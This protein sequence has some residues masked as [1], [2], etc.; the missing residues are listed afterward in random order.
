MISMDKWE[1]KYYLL[2]ICSLHRACWKNSS[3]TVMAPSSLRLPSR[4]HS[5]N[6]D[7]S[8]GQRPYTIWKRLWLNLWASTRDSWRKDLM[9]CFK[10]GF[11]WK[12]T[13]DKLL[14]QWHYC[15]CNHLRFVCWLLCQERLLGYRFDSGLIVTNLALF[16]YSKICFQG[17]HTHLIFQYTV[18][19][20]A[21]WGPNRNGSWAAFGLWAIIWEPLVYSIMWWYSLVWLLRNEVVDPLWD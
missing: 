13:F 10:N 20:N 2:N 17:P 19:L 5:M 15:Y 11:V 7:C 16:V 21:F 6:T 18:H 1:A 8:K 14:I 3:W 12:K 9:I 4:Q